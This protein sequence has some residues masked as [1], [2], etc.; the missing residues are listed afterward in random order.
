MRLAINRRALAAAS[1]GILVLAGIALAA[2]REARPAPA[3]ASAGSHLSVQVVQSSQQAILSSGRL[4]VKVTSGRA[5]TVRVVPRGQLA[6]GS[7]APIKIGKRRRAH[8]RA[9][10]SKTV[11]LG[12]NTAGRALISDC[13]AK[14]LVFTARLRHGG[15]TAAA[16]SRAFGQAPLTLD[17]QQCRSSAGTGGGTSGGGSSGGG[18]GG[19]TNGNVIPPPTPYTG[20]AIGTSSAPQCDFLDPAV[21]LQPFPNDYFTKRD[22]TSATGLRVNFDPNSTP[23]NTHGVHIATDE[24]NR[25]DGFSPGNMVI[26]RIPGLDNPQ[27]F[28]NTG[29][30][31]VNSMSTYA[32]PNQPI[33]VIDA[34]TGQ[35]QP[36][37]S[38]ID[39]NPI[40]P[41]R[42]GGSG[43]PAC[44]PSQ[45]NLIIRPAVNFQEGHRYIVALRGL[46]DSAGNTI[47]PS[48]AFKVYRDNL[49]TTDPKIESRRSHMEDL[50]ETLGE[51]GIQRS[52]LYL[53]WDFTVA[54]R[55]N[56]T[57]RMVSIRDDAFHQ[58]GDDSLG[59]STIQG[60]SPTF[61]VNPAQTQNNVNSNIARIVHGTVQ[62]PCYMNTP[63]CSPDGSTFNYSPADLTNPDRLPVQ[64]PGNM[65]AA[66][67]ECIIP[68]SAVDTPGHPARVSLYGHGLLGS[69]SEVEAGNV[70][71]MANEHNIIFCA[72]DWYGFA[73]TNIPNILLILQDVSQFP[74]LADETQQGMLNF[75]FLGRLA[76]HPQGLDTNAAFHIDGTT[77][78]SQPLINRDRLLYDGN[79][80]GGILGG[81]LTAVA[82]DFRRAVLG[83]PGM[84]YSTLLTRS[85]DFEPYAEG[86]F[87]SAICDEFPAGPLRDTCNLAPQDTPLGLYDNYP[88]RLERPLLFSLMQMLW[89]RAEPD[90]YAQHMTG[91]PLPD[92]PSHT[93]LM[94]ASFGDHQ[95]ANV[96]AEVE[97]RTIGARIYSPTLDPGRYWDPNGVFG[98]QPV[99]GFPFG[100][101]ALI[102]WDGGPIGFSGGTA[103]PPNE[104]IPPRPTSGYGS[105]PH[106][107]PRSDVKAR[108]QKSDFLQLGVLNNYCTTANSPDPLFSALMPN[109]GTAIPCHSNHWTVP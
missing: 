53:T 84:N 18:S 75:L 24:L 39:Y 102:Y 98:L 38:E 23:A 7:S 67:F 78:T 96:A 19:S 68:H 40:D 8:F 9:P 46:K 48:N 43:Q 109:T 10:G 33:V 107:Y 17:A 30:V 72:T 64:T 106:S 79:S 41:A 82:P 20:P 92:T 101:S 76:I 77:T 73:E 21:C 36:I 104:D 32:D 69:A 99:P 87:T 59:D 27:A 86:Q 56:L 88:N 60:N 63:G 55:R 6:D 89:D 57:S 90:G 66:T 91:D 4:N 105:D 35:R 85:V 37:W 108:A 50:F 83:V 58:L 65:A 71:A 74:L 61:S 3:A 93:V 100:G 94:D 44:D 51:A 25:N 52:S 11:R 34:A 81:A 97:A 49:T 45:V 2:P 47:Q 103:T 95:V 1:A 12:L 80:Q 13:R 28:Q 70:E 29:A 14:S 16:G 31:G 54:S 26:V 5:G 15:A 22:P 42:C 62:V